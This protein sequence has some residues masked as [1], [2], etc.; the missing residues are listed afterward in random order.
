MSS[1]P[2]L[3]ALFT[4]YAVQ[5]LKQCYIGQT[6]GFFCFFNFQAGKNDRLGGNKDLVVRKFQMSIWKMYIVFKIYKVA[7]KIIHV[8]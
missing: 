1:I 6:E 5:R 2:Q 4:V 3:R 7:W 8:S